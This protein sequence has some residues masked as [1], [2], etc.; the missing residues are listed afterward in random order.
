M[1]KLWNTVSTILVWLV[2]L[3][4]V[5]MMIFTIV[6]VN[7][8]DR[9]DRAL[10]GYKAFIVLSDSMSATDFDSGDL[11]VVKEVADPSTLQPG[12]IISYQSLNASNYGETVTHK[13]RERTVNE[14]GDPGFITYGTTTG[15]NDEIVVTY[16]FVQGKY[17]FA[18]PHLGEFFVFLK[19]P[20]GYVVCILLPFM[21][22]IFYQ[23]IN[24][25]K[26]FRQYKAEQ[27]AELQAEKDAIEAERKRSEAVMEE[28]RA[29]QAQMA[30]SLSA[31]AP[32]QASA[33]QAEPAQQ[34]APAEQTAPAPQTVSAEQ[35]AA[36]P[37]PAPAAQPDMEAVMAELAALRA[38][39]A[40]TQKEA[41]AA[42]AKEE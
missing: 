27:M 14:N 42:G 3:V 24:C 32:P 8:F 30:A 37:Q 11:V 16:P 13:I 33:P 21:L 25:V 12:D 28:L 20:L 5:A 34:T 18:I 2:V 38:Q 26:I 22:L 35:T 15:T 9:N 10:F 40:A 17:Q 29:M 7:T 1:R 19:T 39:L 4:A 36:E 41:A 23:A 31:Q 6:S